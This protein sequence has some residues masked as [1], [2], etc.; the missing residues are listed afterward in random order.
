MRITAARVT[1]RG[2]TFSI[3]V[4]KPGTI[5]SS[6]ANDVANSLPLDF[7]R[8]VVLAEQVGSSFRYSGRKDIVNFLASIHPSQIPWQDFEIS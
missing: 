5:N 1:E 4:V 8:P 6:I 3:L 2:V 7:P